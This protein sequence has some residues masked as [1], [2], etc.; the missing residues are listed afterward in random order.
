MLAGLFLIACLSFGSASAFE[1]ELREWASFKTSYDKKYSDVTEESY[2][3]PSRAN[4]QCVLVD[5][6]F[7][8]SFHVLLFG[9]KLHFS[10][11]LVAPAPVHK[12]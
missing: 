9:L 8:F 11:F 7:S 10:A 2:V 3:L 5:F 6:F 4:L 12:K 1:A